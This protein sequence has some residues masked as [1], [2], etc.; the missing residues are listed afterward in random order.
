LDEAVEFQ[1]KS[2]KTSDKSTAACVGVMN[3]HSAGRLKRL[4]F[5]F[6]FTLVE[7]LVVIGIIAVLIAILLPA[8]ARARAQSIGV[9]CLSNLRQMGQAVHAYVAENR[10]V[11]P[12][13]Y[14]DYDGDGNVDV[15][16]DYSFVDGTRV[17]GLIWGGSTN[18]AVQQCPAF[19]GR[20]NAGGDPFTGYNYNVGFIGGRYS[21]TES[22]KPSVRLGQIRF[23]AHTAMF[24]DG[25]FSS[26][27]NKYMR[28]PE[29]DVADT[30]PDT[31][32]AAGTQGFR[33]QGRTNVAY[34]DGHA[35]AVDVKP[36]DRFPADW[37]GLTRA[38]SGKGNGFLSVDN[39][40]YDLE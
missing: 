38:L 34:A 4:D 3:R 1:R 10:G 6:A 30:S 24:G 25:Q 35:E 5:K 39:S 12:L 9:K 40:A 26:G 16:W 27:A 28:S 31:T 19:D 29:P 7:L 23:P 18:A 13:A 11:F 32:R 20:S 22:A 2:R 36:A 14:W 17:P 15:G 21:I 37:T 8:L 33:H